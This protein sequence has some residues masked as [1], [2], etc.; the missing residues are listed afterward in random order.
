[1]S[2]TLK[3]SH[4]LQAVT[5]D[6]WAILP[7]KYAEIMAFLSV[8]AHGGD[9]DAE[10][11]AAFRAEAQGRPKQQKMGR[12]AT[13][14]LFGTISHRAGLLSEASG[15]TSVEGFTQQFRALVHDP[16]IDGIV[17]NVDSP[18]GNVAGIEELAAEIYS[19]RNRKPITAVANTLMAS[20][21]YWL[22]SAASELVVSPSA[23]VGS[24]G[25]ISGHEDQ[26]G[27]MEKLGVKVSLV[28]AGKYKAENNPFEPITDEGR[29]EIQKRVDVTYATF[30]RAVAKGRGVSVDSVRGGFGEGRVVGAQEAVKLGMADRIATLDDVVATMPISREADTSTMN[31]GLVAVP[32]EAHGQR[33]AADLSLFVKATRDRAAYRRA[34]EGR[35]PLSAAQRGRL[36]DLNA[37]LAELLAETEPQPAQPERLALVRQAHAR[38]HDLNLWLVE[39]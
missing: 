35:S 39:N 1:M 9:I 18:G 14:P 29:A 4:I 27:L 22:G 30:T 10:T 26:S 5:G 24:I 25:V 38:L 2:S 28:S 7:E 3:Y 6:V 13:L 20:A 21:A 15:G 23:Q 32:Y 12:I 16:E 19:A 8:K 36:A 33:V 17:L 37:E 34:D 31:A 11:L